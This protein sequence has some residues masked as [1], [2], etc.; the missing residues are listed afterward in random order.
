LKRN[1]RAKDSQPPA[2]GS[3]WAS[4]IDLSG[5]VLSH[6]GFV[7]MPKRKT[8]PTD[9]Q[10]KAKALSRWENEGGAKA[11][12]T[13]RPRVLNPRSATGEADRH[14]RAIRQRSTNE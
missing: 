8:H 7:R 9:D 6:V 11:K 14:Q 4:K 1:S 3:T 13:K 2:D 12:R 5:F 10:Q